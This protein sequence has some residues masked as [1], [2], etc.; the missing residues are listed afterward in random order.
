[1]LYLTPGID[2]CGRVADRE[3]RTPSLCLIALY[4]LFCRWGPAAHHHEDEPQQIPARSPTGAPVLFS[5]HQQDQ[6]QWRWLPRACHA[7]V[8]QGWAAALLCHADPCHTEVC[9]GCHETL[10][11]MG[12]HRHL[13]GRCG[14]V[15]QEGL[16]WYTCN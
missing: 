6:N 16:P 10:S 15:L 5:T 9:E 8:N 3:G 2:Q 14:D 12:S 7:G 1:M 11:F 13:T 4:S